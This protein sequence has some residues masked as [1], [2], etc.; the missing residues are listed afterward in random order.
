M[1][2]FLLF[3]AAM[4][5]LSLLGGCESAEDLR[6]F[7]A[8]AGGYGVMQAEPTPAPPAPSDVCE[9]CGGT[10][11]I[12]DGVVRIPCPSRQKGAPECKDGTCPQPRITRR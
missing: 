12:G 9:N 8:V 5:L 1:R 11:F 6:P 3:L 4:A 7:V 2:T 10:G